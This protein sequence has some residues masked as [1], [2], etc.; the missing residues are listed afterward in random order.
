[1]VKK[2]QIDPK[3]PECFFSCSMDGTV[4]YFDLRIKEGTSNGTIIVDLRTQNSRMH[5]RNHTVDVNSI[6]INPIN[7]NLFIC[8]G[9][10]AYVRLYDRRINVRDFE[11]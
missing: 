11:V 7:P 3:S 6:S 10:D 4:R 8:G 9:G 5:R 2:L 1:M